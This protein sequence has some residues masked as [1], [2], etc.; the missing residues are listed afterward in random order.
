MEKVIAKFW[1]MAET[2]NGKVV[3]PGYYEE[4]K[5]TLLHWGTTCEELNNGIGNYTVVFVALNDGSVHEV[6]PSNIK[7]ISP[8]FIRLKNIIHKLWHK[9][10]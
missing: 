7:F 4:K 10:E 5:A 9:V 2:K 6:H 8:F 3:T 1:V